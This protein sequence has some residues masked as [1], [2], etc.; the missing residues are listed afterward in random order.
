MADIKSMVRN[1]GT[2]DPQQADREQELAGWDEETGRRVAAEVGVEMTAE[3][4]S[5]VHGLREHYLEHGQPES[6]RDLADALAEAF[7]EQGGRRYLYKLFP[8]GPVTQGLK[9]AGLPLPAYTEDE[10]FGTAL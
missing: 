6:G 5:V 7:A 2:A 1:G 3:H 9:I 10:G 8:G 4:W